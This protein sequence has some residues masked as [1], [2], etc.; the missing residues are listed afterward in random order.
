MLSRRG[1]CAIS[2][3]NRNILDGV[4]GGNI[5]IFTVSFGIYFRVSLINGLLLFI[6][7]LS[8]KIYYKSGSNKGGNEFPMRGV[9]DVCSKF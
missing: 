1:N 5:D 7:L 2:V 9:K 6:I 8:E 3:I 4:V